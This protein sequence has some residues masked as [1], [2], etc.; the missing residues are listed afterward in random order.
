MGSRPRT[1][2][3]GLKQLHCLRRQLQMWPSLPLRML[4]P[5]HNAQPQGAAAQAPTH[6]AAAKQHIPRGNET[7]MGPNRAQLDAPHA[8]LVALTAAVQPRLT[9][10]T[11]GRAAHTERAGLCTS[12]AE[13]AGRS[14][15]ADFRCSVSK[16]PHAKA[17]GR[18][19]AWRW[20]RRPPPAAQ[21]AQYKHPTT[22]SPAAKQG[23]TQ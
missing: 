18:R 21:V 8:L 1:G 3:L 13:E 14:N 16:R 15:C 4:Q 23:R 5:T 11:R 20:P 19:A 12:K 17:G 7:S 9:H 2:T 10:T 6:R 22:P